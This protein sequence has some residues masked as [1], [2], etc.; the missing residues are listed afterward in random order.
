[1]LR[2]PPWKYLT[3]IFN[4]YCSIHLKQ[5]ALQFWMNWKDYHVLISSVQVLTSVPWHLYMFIF[6]KLGIL[7]AVYTLG[8]YIY[9]IVYLFY[10]LYFTHTIHISPGSLCVDIPMMIFVKAVRSHGL[11][12]CKV[13][14]IVFTSW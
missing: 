11:V 7:C 5:T 2:N 14:F 1:M 3:E 13:L 10:L 6:R 4:N 12:S 8:L 9:Y